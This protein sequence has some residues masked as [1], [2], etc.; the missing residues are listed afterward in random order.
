MAAALQVQIYPRTKYS[1]KGALSSK[2][3]AEQMQAAFCEDRRFRTKA[4][5]W[6][7]ALEKHD[8]TATIKLQ[9][10]PQRAEGV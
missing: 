2:K 4:G 3:K 5:S 8:T 1:K 9:R 6:E 10:N 7:V